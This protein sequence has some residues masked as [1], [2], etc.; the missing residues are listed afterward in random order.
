MIKFTTEYIRRK[1]IGN[2]ALHVKTILAVNE[3]SGKQW[4]HPLKGPLSSS[5]IFRHRQ[6]RH[7]T[8]T[9]TLGWVAEGFPVSYAELITPGNI[10][11]TVEKRVCG[12]GLLDAVGKHMG[13]LYAERS[14][15]LA[16]VVLHPFGQAMTVHAPHI[17]FLAREYISERVIIGE[18]KYEDVTSP[19]VIFELSA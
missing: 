5:D 19:D 12:F 8:K 9:N 3:K 4:G 13:D 11:R 6:V 18:R 10:V 14:R 7:V 17:V 16:E 1:I 2:V 15:A